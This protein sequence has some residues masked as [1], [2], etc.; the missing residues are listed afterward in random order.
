ME[1][2]SS[3]V[4]F[5]D[6]EKEGGVEGIAYSKSWMKWDILR[7]APIPTESGKI[8][9]FLKKE[10]NSIAKK[11][12]SVLHWDNVHCSTVHWDN[13]GIIILISGETG[14]KAA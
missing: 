10:I 3:P 6:E 8:V 14:S 5:S 1:S 13:I 9:E 11:Q 2:A 4:L 7:K 12:K